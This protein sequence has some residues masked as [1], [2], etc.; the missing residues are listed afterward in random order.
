MIAW[1]RAIEEMTG[2]PKEKMLGMGDYAYAV[3]F[4][5]ERR[6]I[7]IDLVMKNLDEHTGLYDFIERH[8]NLLSAE[9][10]VPKAYGG[11]CKYLWGMA[12]PLFDMNGN[13]MRH[14]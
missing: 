8:D 6:P 4:Y 13:L 12:S 5:G 14:N 1:N 11:R 7:L 9:I 2:V 3:P 10:F